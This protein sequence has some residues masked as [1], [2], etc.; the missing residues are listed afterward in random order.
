MTKYI[1]IVLV[2]LS[3]VFAQAPNPITAST[4]VNDDLKNKGVLISFTAPSIPNAATYTWFWGD[5]SFRELPAAFGTSVMHNY[6]NA[7]EFIV[8]LIVADATKHNLYQS[9][10]R[11]R[12]NTPVEFPQ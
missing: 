8:Y 2:L 5:G 4:T 7:S 9:E 3:A 1:A 6:A 11:V 12:I 10:T